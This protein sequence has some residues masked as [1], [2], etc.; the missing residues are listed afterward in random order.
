MLEVFLQA[1]IDINANCYEQGGTDK[2]ADL[3]FWTNGKRRFGG[4]AR[5]AAHILLLSYKENNYLQLDGKQKVTS[6]TIK[7]MQLLLNHGGDP[8]AMLEAILFRA[9]DSVE[10][11]ALIKMLI[12]HGARV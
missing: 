6:S 2:Y 11:D 4:S 8:N 5:S 9:N 12:E 7:I 1:G 10:R 3:A